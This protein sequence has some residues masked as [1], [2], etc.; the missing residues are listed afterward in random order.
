MD[1]TLTGTDSMARI[2]FDIEAN[3]LLEDVTKM[4]IVCTYDLDT[5]ETRQF[6]YHNGFVGLFDYLRTATELVGHNIIGYDLPLLEKLYDFHIEKSVII[7]DT[8]ILSLLLNPDRKHSPGY[9][10][11]SGPHSLDSYGH[12]LGHPKPKHEEWSVFSEEM[13]NRCEQD[14]LLNLATHAL[15]I[16]EW[17]DHDWSLAF[18]IETRVAQIMSAQERRGV[19]FDIY[20]AI[21][22]I[23]ELT[24]A[25]HTIEDTIYALMPT[26]P[27]PASKVKYTAAKPF[28]KDGSY[29]SVFLKG[30][31]WKLIQ[32]PSWFPSP[33]EPLVTHGLISLNNSKQVS[34]YLLSKGW[35]PTEWNYKRV[36]KVQ[37]VDPESPFYGQQSGKLARDDRGK[38]IRTSPKLT[39]DSFGDDLG[40]TPKL[41]IKY[42]IMSHRRSQIKGWV[43]NVRSDG[44]V[45]QGAI[46]CGTNTRRMRHVRV[47]NV[48][49]AESYDNGSGLIWNWDD[50]K[51]FFGTQMRSLFYARD[52]WDFVGYDGSALEVRMEG[53]YTFP[54]DNGEYAREILEGDIHKKNAIS[55]GI[56]KA[57]EPSGVT[58]D[59][60]KRAKPGKYAITYGCAPPKFAETL[61]FPAEEGQELYD[62]YWKANWALASF[63]D[64]SEVEWTVNGGWVQ[65][66]DGGKIGIR[67]KHSIVNA[68]F[69]SAGSIVMKL[70]MI[71]LD[72][73][74]ELLGL[75]AFKVIDMH[76]EGQFICHP[77]DTQKLMELMEACIVQAGVQLN[78]KVPL[79]A[80]AIVGRNWAETH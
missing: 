62:A 58:K 17:G 4:W 2:L 71:I 27:L 50:Q 36:T 51:V 11:S 6:T 25:M 19:P 75:R 53:H 13:R 3:N 54:Y 74:I 57:L 32:D 40:E 63:R 8:L 70:S 59:E 35:V 28:K 10:G 65:S 31:G 73:W 1:V 22:Y 69:Q 66:I 29:S 34:E 43:E 41:I 76:D 5:Q 20:K 26:V 38:I 61:G 60:R 68:K 49:G 23:H 78:F 45:S 46:T 44:T 21:K 55:L 15:L 56:S 77:E 24:V 67:S 16:E 9:L 30:A 39:E 79:A 80:E 37:A 47:V 64:D 48:P 14:V 72:D 52:G 18:K 7:T 42:R 12:T 33:H